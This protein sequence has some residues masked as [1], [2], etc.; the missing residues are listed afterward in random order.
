MAEKEK[1]TDKSSFRMLWGRVTF[2]NE[3]LWYRLAVIILMLAAMVV[4]IKLFPSGIMN[5]IKK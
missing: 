1:D 2:T 3:P 5:L 4:M